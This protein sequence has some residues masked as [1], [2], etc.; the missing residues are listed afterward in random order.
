MELDIY[1]VDAFTSEVFGGN[2]AA[3]VP[4]KEWLPDSL[5]QSIAEENNLAETAYFVPK[6][7]HFEIRWFMPHAEIDLCGHAT[8]ASAY[9]IF[10]F[11]RPDLD[12]VE[13]PSQSG[14]LKASQ[15]DGKIE[16][17]FPTRAPEPI[18]IPEEVFESFNYK[19]LEAHASR[20]LILLFESEEQIRTIQYQLKSLKHLPYLGIVPTAKGEK[21]DF[22]SRVFDAVASM[23]EDPVTGST[24][25]TLIPFWSKRLGKDKLLAHQ[26][27]DRG[28]VLYCKQAGDRVYIAGNAVLYLKGK[29]YL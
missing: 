28:G 13:F 19:P 6:G 14:P 20:D 12:V 2:P 1:Q 26:L 23:P 25:A 15:K 9:V 27:S 21:A 8:L 3:V 29:I 4:L 11:L 5:M 24:H 10:N 22:V 7:D 18:E 16:L 17:D